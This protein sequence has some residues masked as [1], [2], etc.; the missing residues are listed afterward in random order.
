M[1]AG[2]SMTP[3]NDLQH[4]QW[5][6]GQKGP[7]SVVILTENKSRRKHTPLLIGQS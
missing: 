7:G 3:L 1:S 6:P 5:F 2:S 4:M